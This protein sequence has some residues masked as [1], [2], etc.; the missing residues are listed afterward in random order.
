MGTVISREARLPI[1]FG[2][3]YENRPALSIH[4]ERVPRAA[5]NCNRKLWQG[6]ITAVSAADLQQCLYVRSK[7]PRLCSTITRDRPSPNVGRRNQ[8]HR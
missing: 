2:K 1:T 5:A 6:P 8:Q 3:R 4:S 7:T